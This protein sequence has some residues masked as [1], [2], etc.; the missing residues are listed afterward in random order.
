MIWTW[1]W[2]SK[3]AYALV[4]EQLER[5]TAER[6]EYRHRGDRLYDETILRF[7]YEAAAPR[8]RQEMAADSAQAAEDFSSAIVMDDPM[9]GMLDDEVEAAVDAAVKSQNLVS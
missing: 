5:V 4:V 8:V 7:G 1:P 3:R 9:G 6:D 2:V